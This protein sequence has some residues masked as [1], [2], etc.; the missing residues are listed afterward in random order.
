M[1]K[2]PNKAD[3]EPRV[4]IIWFYR[5]RLIAV[6][7]LLSE[8]EPYGKALTHPT[9]HIEFWSSLQQRGTVPVDVEYEEPPRGR[10]GYDKERAAFFLYADRCIIKN[11][12]A[13][14]AILAAFHLPRDVKPQ[15][16]AH[17]LCANCMSR[18]RDQG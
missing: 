3:V 13:I 12:T 15:P 2:Q 18:Q 6:T 9:G 10:V 8:A 5:R 11:S 14:R 16:D 1:Q 4:G 7:T 17:Y